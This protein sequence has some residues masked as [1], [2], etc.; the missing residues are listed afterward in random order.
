MALQ[1]CLC[2]CIHVETH[3]GKLHSVELHKLATYLSKGWWR[4]RQAWSLQPFVR[5][6][7]QNGA[8]YFL[9]Y[10]L[11]Q[12]DHA[13]SECQPAIQIVRHDLCN[14]VLGR[15][16]DRNIERHTADTIVSW[17]NPKQWV[18]V[19]TSD[20]MMIIRQSIYILS[21]MTRE[22]VNWKTYNPY[23]V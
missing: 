6:I 11:P 17:P 23:L 19:H 20:L 9:N 3:I 22:M 8:I 4:Q 5:P 18:I 14:R 2:I 13:F 15:R 16:F 7:N 1:A 12:L 10:A 21:I